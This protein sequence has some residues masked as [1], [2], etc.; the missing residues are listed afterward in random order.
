MSFNTYH[1]VE[2]SFVISYCL[3][4]T[5]FFAVSLLITCI[6][7]FQL[8]FIYSEEESSKNNE[9]VDVWFNDARIDALTSILI[10]KNGLT[11][12]EFTTELLKGINN[13]CSEEYKKLIIEKA[14]IILPQQKTTI[15][16]A[17]KLMV[18][19]TLHF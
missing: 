18:V 19:F 2:L 13:D 16:L 6:N 15:K 4:F 5:I 12:E 10:N 11:K 9:E 1:F 8:S 17:Y 3:F 14:K 7:I